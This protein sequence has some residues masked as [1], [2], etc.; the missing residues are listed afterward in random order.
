MP[1]MCQGVIMY[2][3]VQ[4]KTFSQRYNFVCFPNRL[5]KGCYQYIPAFFSDEMRIFSDKK[6][7]FSEGTV[8]KYFLCYKDGKIVGRIGG[9][10]SFT[11]TETRSTDV[12]QC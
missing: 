10:I 6:N 1:A 3:I 5:Y 9:I 4:V 7:P 8:S 12:T 11:D 2:K